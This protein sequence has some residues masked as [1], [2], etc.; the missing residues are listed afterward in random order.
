M[1]QWPYPA[2]RN[3]RP[4]LTVD[5]PLRPDPDDIAEVPTCKHCGSA[6]LRPNGSYLSVRWD[7]R[8]DAVVCRDCHR[9]CYLPLGQH[10]SRKPERAPEQFVIA[11]DRRPACP[12]CQGVRVTR[13]GVLPCGTQRWY[14][15]ACKRRFVS[16]AHRRATV[17][18][19]FASHWEPDNPDEEARALFAMAKQTG[20]FEDMREVIGYTESEK[21]CLEFLASA[22]MLADTNLEAMLK[23]RDDVLHKFDSLVDA[24]MLVACSDNEKQGE[25]IEETQ[26]ASE[27]VAHG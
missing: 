24:E 17:D 8:R 1:S 10:L 26:P 16:A 23:F 11:D 19:R 3:P 22:G 6:N 15:A 14:C 7:E 13:R 18:R 21:R 25:Q 9:S 4:E 2:G 20:A 12:Y 5:H 27:V